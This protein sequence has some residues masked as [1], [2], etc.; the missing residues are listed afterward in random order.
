M[1]NYTS[2][3]SNEIK[4]SNEVKAPTRYLKIN[5]LDQN[6]EYTITVMSST[7]KGYGPASEPIFVAPDQDSKSMF[8]LYKWTKML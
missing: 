5:G 1:S 8:A 6:T 4:L 7:S 2:A 3:T